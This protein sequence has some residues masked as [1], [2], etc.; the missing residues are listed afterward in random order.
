M[1][2]SKVKPYSISEFIDTGLLRFVNIFFTFL[3]LLYVTVSVTMVKSKK[4][5]VYK[6]FV[7]NAVDSLRLA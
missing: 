6:L 2:K 7:L 1:E 5:K 3:G 4:K